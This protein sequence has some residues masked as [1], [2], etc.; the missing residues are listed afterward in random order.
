M[1]VE[2]K[3]SGPPL[4][5]GADRLTLHTGLLYRQPI[6]TTSKLLKEVSSDRVISMVL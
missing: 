6:G 1:Q 5:P 4:S 3:L 2:I